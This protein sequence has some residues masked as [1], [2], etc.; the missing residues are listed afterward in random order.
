MKKFLSFT[1]LLA[2]ILPTTIFAAWGATENHHCDT[3]CE[4]I[5]DISSSVSVSGYK[6]NQDGHVNPT[7]GYA[8]C[9]ASATANRKSSGNGNTGV[10]QCNTSASAFD[11]LLV[12]NGY[13]SGSFSW[14]WKEER[15]NEDGVFT[16]EFEEPDRE[17]TESEK[18][19]D[20]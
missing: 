4:K 6:S 9:G 2:S 7:P 15:L 19:D 3:G 14:S 13:G 11:A 20:I 10:G 18:R 17:L 16:G 5:A 12:D 1:L 8:S